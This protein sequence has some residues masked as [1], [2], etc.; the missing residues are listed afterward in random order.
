MAID[1]VSSGLVA[2]LAKP[3]GNVTGLSVQATNLAGKRLELLRG[4]V[5][6][7]RRL[8]IMFNVGNAQPVLEM[9]ETQ[10]AARI[11]DL[12]RF[13]DYYM[14]E[15]TVDSLIG[16]RSYQQMRRMLSKAPEKLS[17]LDTLPD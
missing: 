13:R 17:F 6:Q 9:G 3:G 4:V 15:K 11:L 14:N 8:A 7:V 1:P 5:P 10:A 12:D 16:M 2:G